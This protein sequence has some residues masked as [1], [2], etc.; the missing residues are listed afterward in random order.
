MN[1]CTLFIIIRISLL[2]W[3]K[4]HSAAGVPLGTVKGAVQMQ[5]F[6]LGRICRMIRAAMEQWKP[7]NAAMT[8]TVFPLYRT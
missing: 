1:P 6:H 7:S 4:N 3:M 2:S 5:G 8:F